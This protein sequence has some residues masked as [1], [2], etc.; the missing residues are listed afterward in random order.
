R[1]LHFPDDSAGTPGFFYMELENAAASSSSSSTAV[2]TS[3][4]SI[5]SSSSSKPFFMPLVATEDVVV[6]ARF[7]PDDWYLAYVVGNQ[8]QVFVTTRQDVA[9]GKPGIPLTQ[10]WNKE[11]H[12][13]VLSFFW[14]PAGF[15][16]R[17]AHGAART[18]GAEKTQP[19]HLVPSPYEPQT[20]ELDANA[21][22]ALPAPR[23]P[24]EL[25]VV[26]TCGIEIFRINIVKH[27]VKSARTYQTQARKVWVEPKKGLMVCCIGSRTLQPFDL[28]PR[29]TPQKLPKFDLY[30]GKSKSIEHFDVN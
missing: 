5:S 1:A 25:V 27:T 28:R 18:T 6:D 29:R 8:E 20:T 13:E 9:D 17:R 19:A 7:A 26:S 4:S 23:H 15:I 12:Y 2:A 24:L 10:K 11:R 14:S 21:G 30:I 3:S 22:M 16:P